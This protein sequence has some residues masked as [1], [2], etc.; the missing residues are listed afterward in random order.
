M[1]MCLN[2]IWPIFDLTQTG[3]HRKAVSYSGRGPQNPANTL[4]LHIS[5]KAMNGKRQNRTLLPT[6]CVQKQQNTNVAKKKR[7]IVENK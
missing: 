2:T 5:K 4:Q 7:K 6:G 3:N 1:H